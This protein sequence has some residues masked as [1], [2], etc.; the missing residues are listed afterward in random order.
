[1]DRILE[2]PDPPTIQEKRLARSEQVE[3]KRLARQESI[4]DRARRKT[5]KEADNVVGYYRPVMS[6]II[7]DFG[8]FNAPARIMRTCEIEA[9]PGNTTKRTMCISGYKEFWSKVFMFRM[10]MGLGFNPSLRLPLE[11]L[12][13]AE[14]PY[15]F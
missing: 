12:L 13:A 4:K 9:A 8:L 15:V 2:K 6:R 11:L 5:C 14:L 10:I 7:N 1:M 3:A